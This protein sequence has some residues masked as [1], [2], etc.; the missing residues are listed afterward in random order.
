LLVILGFKISKTVFIPA[1][2]FSTHSVATWISGWGQQPA[3]PFSEWTQELIDKY[4]L[5]IKVTGMLGGFIY[6]FSLIALFV[7]FLFPSVISDRKK[8]SD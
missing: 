6:T 4:L 1:L 2:Y 5:T 7:T 3:E 8:I